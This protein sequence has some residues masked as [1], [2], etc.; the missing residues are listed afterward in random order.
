[1][2]PAGTPSAKV[3]V[4]VPALDEADYLSHLLEDLSRLRLEHVVLVVDGGSRDGTVAAARAAGA[5]VMRSRRGR[6]RQ[7]NAGARGLRSPWLFFVHADSRLGEGALR[8]IEDHVRADRPEAGYFRL[9]ISHPH[10]HYRIIERG[11]RVREWLSSLVYGDQGLLIRRDLF[12][13]SG[14]YPDEPIMED[15]VLNRRLRRAG[16]LIRLPA[17]IS[18]SP[19]RYEEEGRLNAWLRNVGL[20]SRF[21]AGTRPSDLAARYPARTRGG[22][23]ADDAEIAGDATEATLLVF[24]KAPRPGEVKTRLAR[25]LGRAGS[26]DHDAAAALYRRMGRLI[27][28]RV[29]EAPAIVTVCYDPPGAEA[30]VRDW[31][32]P[33]PERFWEQGAGDLGERISRMFARALECSRRAV[34]IGTDTPAVGA[35][36]VARALAALDTADVVLGPSRDGGYYLMALREPCPALFRGIAWSTEAVLRETAARA[37]ERGLRVTLLEVES[38][39]DTAADLTGEVAGWLGMG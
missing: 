17:A 35:A 36:T 39:V 38:D 26:P 15:V 33:G 11:Q 25:S 1:M 20:V 9:L 29:A 3:G 4:V 16:R 5:G 23:G 10:F 18:T 32:G 28:D 22:A 27:V 8:A 12:L 7:M 31:L 30:E 2:L 13:A 6:A 21:L 37:R 34:V 14:P 24:A 19:R